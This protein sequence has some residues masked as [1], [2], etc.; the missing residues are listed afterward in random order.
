MKAKILKYLTIALS[1]LGIVASTETI[2]FIPENIGTMVV[3]A[4]VILV[5]TFTKVGDLLDDG[6]LNDSFKPE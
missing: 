6:K 3:G 2:P 1:A 5:S 4:A